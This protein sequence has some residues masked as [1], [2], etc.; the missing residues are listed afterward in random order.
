MRKV[1]IIFAALAVVYSPLSATA[2]SGGTDKGG[3]HTEKKTGKRHCHGKPKAKQAR[4]T[5][6]SEAKTYSKSLGKGGD[7]N[8]PD[9]ATQTAAQAFYIKNGGPKFDLHKLDADKDGIACESNK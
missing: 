7:Y 8:C 5:A 1:L 2:H 3:C 9:F 4:P 6:R